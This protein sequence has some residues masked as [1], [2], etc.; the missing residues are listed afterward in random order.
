MEKRLNEYKSKKANKKE[1]A[2]AKVK[3]T[4]EILESDGTEMIEEI[5]EVV[6]VTEE[7][8]EVTKGAE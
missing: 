4:E 8:N 1:K 6:A 5:E 3:E 2:K 7:A